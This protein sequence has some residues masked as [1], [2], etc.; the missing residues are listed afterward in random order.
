[1]LLE[2]FDYKSGSRIYTLPGSTNTFARG[3]VSATTPNL[4]DAAEL[5]TFHS[6][7]LELKE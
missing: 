4:R 5:L 2:V 1:M 7:L 3:F 6:S